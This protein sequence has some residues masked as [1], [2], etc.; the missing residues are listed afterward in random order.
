ME[1]YNCTDSL[2]FASHFYND[3]KDVHTTVCLDNFNFY[4]AKEIPY[5]GWAQFGSSSD[6]V[7]AICALGHEPV[8]KNATSIVSRAV[9]AGIIE[10]NTYSFV[11][12]PNT[13]YNGYTPLST[14]N[15]RHSEIKSK[16]SR[17]RVGYTSPGFSYV[18][19][20][21]YDPDDFGNGTVYWLKIGTV[22]YGCWNYSAYNVTL[23]GEQILDKELDMGSVFSF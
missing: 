21:G 10:N 7:Q 16:A 17:P 12:D 2:C 1:G 4:M 9:S 20:G 15:Q 5:D 11:V 13:A 8:S 14:G 22:C 23:N 19:I 6:Q 18:G 3:D